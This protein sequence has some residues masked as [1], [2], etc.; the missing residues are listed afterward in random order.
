MEEIIKTVSEMTG[1][2][3][4]DMMSRKRDRALCEARQIFIYICHVK[5][6]IPISAIARYINGRSCQTIALQFRSMEQ[7]IRIY[8][9][10]RKQVNE[11]EDAIM[12]GRKEQ[13]GGSYETER[14]FKFFNGR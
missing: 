5:R 4:E 3:V 12:L 1:I 8:K 14:N 2:S 9:L 6:G 13:N 7:Q 10:L 11:I